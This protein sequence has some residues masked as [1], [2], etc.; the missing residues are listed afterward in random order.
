MGV[1]ATLKRGS[2]RFHGMDVIALIQWPAM[3]STILASWLVAS[4]KK[5]RRQWGFW[6]F[7]ASNVLWVIWGWHDNAWALIALQF[8]LAFMNIRGVAKN[9]PA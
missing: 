8:A 1:A 2:A 4:Q 9:E 5:Q 7:L 3:L 6:V